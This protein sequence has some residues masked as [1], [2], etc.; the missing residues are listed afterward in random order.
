VRPAPST[1][2]AL[3]LAAAVALG[4]TAC[5]SS[6]DDAGGTS[7]TP[8]P[9]ATLTVG[10]VLEPTDLDI[11]RTS[12][13]ALDQVLID[14]VYQGL[15][16]RTQ[17]AEIVDVL[18]S[19]H[20]IS[21][22]GL[23]YTF[24]LRDDVT[25]AGTGD[26]LTADDVTWSLQQVADDETLVGHADLAAVEEISSPDPS[27]V[28]LTLSRPD[29]SLLWSLTGRAGLVLEEDATNDLSTTSNGTGPFEVARWNQGDSL[30]LARVD[31]TWGEPAGVAG[32]TFRYV[33]DGSAAINAMASG[34]VDVQTA[35][36][37]T[38]RSQLDGVDGVTV[39]EGRT[40]D[41]YTLAFNN[42]REPFTDERVRRALRLAVDND[43][44][45]AAVGGSAVDQGGPVPEL[46]PGYEDLTDVDAF[47]PD[48][49]RDLLEEAGATDLQLTLEYPNI[50]SPAI[51]DVLASQYADVGVT[52]EVRQVEFATWLQD[53]YTDHDFEL[54][55]VNHAE[56]HDLGNWADPDYYWGY[57]SPE[58]QALYAEALAAT[59]P[60]A[61]DAALAEAARVVSEDAP[62]EW[63]YTATTLTAVRDGVSGFPT[64]STSARLDLTTVTTTA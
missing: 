8:D 13:I 48:A 44:L 27:T 40:T 2:A 54:S 49:A 30:Q 32:V 22:D 59:D 63:L 62:A 6:S 46:D 45:I 38:L 50:Y 12:G 21:D 28:V 36:D 17:D 4:A 25:F 53:V 51:G 3:A 61:A 58:V 39:E 55:M 10:L 41:K 23:R 34:D 33:T 7:G 64:E 14:N 19:G 5:S 24:T 52:L 16:G 11:R 35:V 31:D 57:D 9:D 20:E 1:A 60:D 37:A 43:A 56:S 29:S 42:A 26:A 47:D 18:A 15:V